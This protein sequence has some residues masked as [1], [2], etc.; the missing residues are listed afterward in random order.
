MPVS[1]AVAGP[2]FL[3]VPVETIFVVAGVVPPVL[4][5]VALAAG[6]MRDT[7]LQRPLDA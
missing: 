2:L 7:E 4:A 1:I 3:I 6:R 5:A